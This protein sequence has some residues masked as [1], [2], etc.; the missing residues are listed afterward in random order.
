M[1][2]AKAV[3]DGLQRSIA[4]GK[5]R[6]DARGPA[7]RLWHVLLA[8]ALVGATAAALVWLFTR[9]VHVAVSAVYGAL[10]GIVPTLLAGNRMLRW[11]APGS[12]PATA[13]V[14]LLVWEMVRLFL[15]FGI[16]A[17]ASRVLGEPS[18]PAL[19]IGLV[20]AI[21]VYWVALLVVHSIGSR[22]RAGTRRI[23]G[24]DC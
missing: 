21:K 23:L 2:P 24:N 10:A 19:L 13:L 22:Q 5:P 7:T 9:Q 16:L 8:Q 14:G 18:W 12:S 17:M 15:V 11:A 6:A 4:P 1:Y 3:S 20:L